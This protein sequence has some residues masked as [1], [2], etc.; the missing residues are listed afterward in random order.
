[1]F[2]Y[3]TPLTLEYVM[4]V[5]L[6]ILLNL[7]VLLWATS[8]WPD[9]GGYFIALLPIVLTFA[10]CLVASSYTERDI[11]SPV[12]LMP[13]NTFLAILVTA[14][15]YRNVSPDL[16]RSYIV[17]VLI[18]Y[19]ILIALSPYA[20]NLISS[21]LGVYGDM[22][23]IKDNVISY[24]ILQRPVDVVF[25]LDRQWLSLQCG[26]IVVE[27]KSEE[28]RVKLR[29]RRYQTNLH[30]AVYGVLEAGQCKTLLNMVPYALV[31]NMRAKD[32]ISDLRIKQFLMPQVEEIVKN[33][34]AFS[35]PK[36]ATLPPG[37]ILPIPETVQYVLSPT[38]IARTMT[39]QKHK[40][41]AII[42]T[43]TGTMIMFL[44]T[45]RLA[46]MLNDTLFTGL[47]GLAVAVGAFVIAYLSRK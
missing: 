6:G 8:T 33:L 7:G 2:S 47:A 46:N 18:F 45:L 16:L 5:V 20:Q 42:A 26:M 39:L 1:M 25:Q 36:G 44:T 31:Q 13:F 23:S 10:Y 37:T 22:N 41:E 9:S 21:I 11:I 35:V 29:L 32:I 30:L 28:N 17:G 3:R 15:T 27:N 14:W 12:F 38:R 43:L 19:L 24:E 40:S 34:G 4:V